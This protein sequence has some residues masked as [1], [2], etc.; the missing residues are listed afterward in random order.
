MEPSTIV[1]LLLKWLVIAMQF[2]NVASLRICWVKDNLVL[3]YV[4]RVGAVDCKGHT[5]SEINHLWL[6][7]LLSET[8]TIISLKCKLDSQPTVKEC[9]LA[10]N[11]LSTMVLVTPQLQGLM[12]LSFN[13][14]G[15]FSI[16]FSSFIGFPPSSI[17]QL[18]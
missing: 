18:S 8:V 4:L 9:Q 3:R 15:D 11:M 5:S 16:A 6:G 7:R 1:R 10:L 13:A 17:L 14:L 12:K 2:S